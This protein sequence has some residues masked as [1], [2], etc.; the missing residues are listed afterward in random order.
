MDLFDYALYLADG[1]G[2]HTLRF[3]VDDRQATGYLLV[4]AVSHRVGKIRV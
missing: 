3:S 4:L 1:E 2:W